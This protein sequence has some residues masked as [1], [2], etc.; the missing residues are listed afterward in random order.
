[1]AGQVFVRR[2]TVRFGQVDAAG[3]IFYPRYFE[4]ISNTMEA[5]FAEALETPFAALH[6]DEAC[7]TPAV[8]VRATFLKASRLGDVLD[9]ALR[10][11]D[12]GR[13]RMVLG[14]EAQCA[15]EVRMRATVTHVFVG[16]EPL[17]ARAIPDDLR[18]RMVAYLAT[19]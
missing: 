2:E 7:G 15:N 14:V 17:K 9:L 4:M 13:S 16:L 10:V 3:L 6:L 18:A 19:T 12:L 11:E 8:E 1:M 5:W